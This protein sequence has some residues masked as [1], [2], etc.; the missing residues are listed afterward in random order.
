M[1]YFIKIFNNNGLMNKKL[2]L[3]TPC[4]QCKLPMK[5]VSIGCQSC[6]VQVSAQF[7]AHPLL[8]LTSEELHFLMIFIHCEGKIGDMEKALGISYPTVKAKIHK[9]KSKLSE[10]LQD[11]KAD[12]L[13][14]LDKLEKGEINFDVVLEK[15]AKKNKGKKS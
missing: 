2:E 7:E 3:N 13:K 14:L 8:S 10:D 9:L 6:D 11:N 1:L 4:P 15:I 5:P 12:T